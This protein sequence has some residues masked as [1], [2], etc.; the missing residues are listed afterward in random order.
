MPPAVPGQAIVT[1]A[2]ALVT[3]LLDSTVNTITLPAG[4]TTMTLGSSTLAITRDLTISVAGGASGRRLQSASPADVVYP[5]REVTIESRHAGPTFEVAAG[6]TVTLVGVRLTNY[7]SGNAFVPDAESHAISNYGTLYLT[8]CSLLNSKAREGTAIRNYATGTVVAVRTLFADNFNQFGYRGTVYNTG[9]T[10]T[11]TDCAMRNNQATMSS[12]IA[13]EGGTVLLERTDISNNWAHMGGAS[14][15]FNNQMGTITMRGCTVRNNEARPTSVSGLGG[16]LFNEGGDLLIE[17]SEFIGNRAALGGAIGVRFEVGVNTTLQLARTIFRANAAFGP[18][19]GYSGG[20]GGALLVEAGLLEIAQC[21]FED[22]V[23][24]GDGGAIAVSDL[25]A[26]AGGTTLLNIT[27]SSFHGNRAGLRG[28][29]ILNLERLLHMSNVNITSNVAGGQTVPGLGSIAGAG[30]FNSGTAYLETVQMAF[31]VAPTGSGSALYN[32][33]TMTFI[34]PTAPGEWV[35]ARECSIYR[36]SCTDGDTFCQLAVQTPECKFEIGRTAPVL[37]DAV[38]TACPAELPAGL[39][40]CAW[41]V[42]PFLLGKHI[43]MLGQGAPDPDGD[44]PFACQPG[45]IGGT[46]PDDQAGPLCAGLCPAGSFCREPRTLISEICTPGSYCSAGTVVPV[47]C[48]AGT[49]SAA[50]GVT[51]P[52]QCVTVPPGTWAAAGSQ[53]PTKC[54][55][56]T[57]NPLSGQTLSSAC[58]ECAARTTTEFDSSIVETDCLCQEGWYKTYLGGSAECK[59]CPEEGSNCKAGNVELRNGTG[60]LLSRLPA[61]KDYWRTRNTTDNLR[62]CG[63]SDVCIDHATG[64]S[65]AGCREGHVGPYCGT[66]AANYFLSSATKLCVSCDGPGSGDLVFVILAISIPILMLLFVCLF[67][68]RS[69][70]Q[71]VAKHDDLGTNAA[72]RA[73]GTFDLAMTAVAEKLHMKRREKGCLSGARMRQVMVKLKIIISLVQVVKQMPDVYALPRTLRRVLSQTY[74]SNSPDLR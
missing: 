39:Q 1:G 19:P 8:D 49:S 42:A 38:P 61:L 23:A 27:D 2:A 16:A 14:T 3:A 63:T 60:A 71:Y 15:I 9:G 29:A 17:D 57:Y 22:N 68:V 62:L 33:G 47:P 45:L 67:T 51:G 54:A 64:Y 53:Y 50:A 41:S 30:I 35:P 6:V 58:L 66:C 48:P 10:V 26:S 59:V 72:N 24:S 43:S 34:L 52:S 74:R 13:N 55:K 73:S 11:L 25:G 20:A 28:A 31:N 36:E 7:G 32:S 37:I 44:F 40:P 70:R 4:A 69:V 18:P 46:D 21:T 56:G 12:A 65:G 5:E